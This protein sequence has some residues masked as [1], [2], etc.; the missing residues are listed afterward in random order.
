M[1]NMTYLFASAMIG[2]VSVPI[3]RCAPEVASEGMVRISKRSS[4][5]V[6]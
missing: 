1:K 6:A 4:N 3:V 5:S 2:I